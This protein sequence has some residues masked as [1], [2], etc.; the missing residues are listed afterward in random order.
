MMLKRIVLLFMSV[1][2]LYLR[3][4]LEDSGQNITMIEKS[5]L[6]DGEENDSHQTLC[7]DCQAP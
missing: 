1:Q 7:D 2:G 4:V 3:K 5:W 6:I